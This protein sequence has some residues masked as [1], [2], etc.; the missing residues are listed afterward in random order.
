MC[1]EIWKYSHS[2]LSIVSGFGIRRTAAPISV[3]SAKVEKLSA[4]VDISISMTT[5]EP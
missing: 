1:G 2:D 5:Y 3:L 4:Q